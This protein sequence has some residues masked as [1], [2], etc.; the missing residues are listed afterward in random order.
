M[1]LTDKQRKMLDRMIEADI[2]FY[3]KEAAKRKKDKSPPPKLD[4]RAQ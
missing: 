1:A 2:Y 4:K 3:R